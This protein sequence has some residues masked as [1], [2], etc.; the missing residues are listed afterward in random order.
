MTLTTPLQAAKVSSSS[1]L[2]LAGAIQPKGAC[3][4]DAILD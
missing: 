4:F 2:L 3:D 1:V